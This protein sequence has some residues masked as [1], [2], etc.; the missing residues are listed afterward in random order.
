VDHEYVHEAGKQAAKHQS[1]FHVISSMG[2]NSD[3]MFYYSRVKG[4]MEHSLK[5]LELPS[6]HIYRPSLLLGD[7]KEFRLGEKLVAPISKLILRGP[8]HRFQPNH[9]SSVANAMLQVSKIG[10]I[11]VHVYESA[12]IE[13]I[14]KRTD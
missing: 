4:Q 13:N 6:L 11:G 10:K 9:V 8:L 5:K 2:A 3:S 7:R 12:Q 14:A 1:T